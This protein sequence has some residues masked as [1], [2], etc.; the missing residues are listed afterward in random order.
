MG[1]NSLSLCEKKSAFV[2][3][4]NHLL[5]YISQWF[6]KTRGLFMKL[7]F[8]LIYL[9]ITRETSFLVNIIFVFYI[10]IVIQFS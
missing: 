4:V 5:V 2:R 6:R 9:D 10:L 8:V 3:Q 1:Y 7:D